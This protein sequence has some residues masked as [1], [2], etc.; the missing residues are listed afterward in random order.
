MSND[1][2]LEFTVVA[3]PRMSLEV[4]NEMRD[5][6][7]EAIRKRG[8]DPSVF[9]QLML[10]REALRLAEGAVSDAQSLIEEYLGEFPEDAGKDV[11][12]MFRAELKDVVQYTKRNFLADG[13]IECLMPE[14]SVA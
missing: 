9:D 6:L 7:C 1:P 10:D 2:K 3:Y 4:F 5:F 12:E 14:P 8:L 13:G 11:S